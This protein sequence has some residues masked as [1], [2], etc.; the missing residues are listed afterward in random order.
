LL[1]TQ[2]ATLK[3]N[4]SPRVGFGFN[5][6][7]AANRSIVSG[8][9]YSVFGSGTT[10]PAN[11]VQICGVGQSTPGIST[12]IP[13][14]KG[15]GQFTYAFPSGASIALGADYEGKNNAYYQPPMAIA[16]LQIVQPFSKELGLL[17]SVSNLFNTNAFQYLPA[18]NLGVPL[19][20]DTVPVPGGPVQQTSYSSTLIPAIARTLRA[21]LTFH[22]G[23]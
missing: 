18:P 9:P 22:L 7:A 15:Y 3:Y 2:L 4:Y 14:L 17:V 8:I 20:A 1:Q 19:V 23:Q 10:L 13:Y 11:N 6:S 5:L 12:C 16:D 21:S